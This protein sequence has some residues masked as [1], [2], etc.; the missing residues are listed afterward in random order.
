MLMSFVR[1]AGRLAAWL[2]AAV[3]FSTTLIADDR[4]LYSLESGMNELV[5]RLSR[6]VVT[7]ESS[8]RPGQGRVSRLPAGGVVQSLISSGIICDSSGHIVVAAAAVAGRERILVTFD[9]RT[10]PA[11]VVAVDYPTE[12]AVLHVPARLGAPVTYSSRQIC[13][14]QLVVAMGNAYGMRA[15][16]TL[17]FCAGARSDGMLQFTARITSGS[18]GGGVFDLS[19]NLLGVVTGSMGSTD[20][21]ML[22]VPAYQLPGI[23]EFLL[24]KGD[25]PAGFIG[26]STVD[27]ETVDM[28]RDAEPGDLTPSVHAVALSLDKGVVVT[29]VVPVS[30]AAVAGIRRGDVITGFGHQ[31]VSSAAELAQWVKQTRPGSLVSL[32]FIRNNTYADIQLQIGRKTLN[33]SQT[34]FGSTMFDEP[35]A[36]SPDSLTRLIEYLKQEVSRLESRVERFR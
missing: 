19:G 34:E 28:P 27:I 33:A 14:G 36:P 13:A 17:G 20:A 11:K 22:A 15:T 2:F 1:T 24:T 16:P 31:P 25:R 32:E 30:P 29:Y 7:V 26:V 18:K 5:Y 9:N 4:P 10:L 3:F 12:L 6:S 21:V 8:N 35:S 23:V